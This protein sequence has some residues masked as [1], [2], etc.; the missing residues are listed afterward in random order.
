MLPNNVFRNVYIKWDWLISWEICDT[1]RKNG[2]SNVGKPY[3]NCCFNDNK[4][5][6][7]CIGSSLE[8]EWIHYVNPKRKPVWVKPGEPGPSTPKANMVV[9]EGDAL[10]LVG[11]EGSRLL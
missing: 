8:D 1:N 7:F 4:G 10:Y 6:D 2:T 11:Y 5:R 9:V 3:P